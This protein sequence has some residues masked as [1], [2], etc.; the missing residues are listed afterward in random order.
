MLDSTFRAFVGGL[1]ETR[2]GEGVLNCASKINCCTFN[3]SSAF[4]FLSLIFFNSLAMYFAN[5]VS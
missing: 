1:S 5:R 4:D 3:F 2:F